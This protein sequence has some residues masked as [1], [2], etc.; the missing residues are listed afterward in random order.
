MLRSPGLAAKSVYPNP[1]NP[2][3]LVV[4]NQGTDRE[5]LE[6]LTLVR[7]VYAGAGLPDFL[8]FDREISRRGWGGIIA[9]GFFDSGWQL[10]PGLMYYRGE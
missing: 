2:E 7:T 5:G 1:L 10:D 6:L 8:I 3:K 4:M 9:A